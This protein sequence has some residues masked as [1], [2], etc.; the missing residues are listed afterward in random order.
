ML[1]CVDP[2]GSRCAFGV[3]RLTSGVWVGAGEELPLLF[4]SELRLLLAIF[5]LL[6]CL[7]CGGQRTAYREYECTRAL[8]VL[9]VLEDKIAKY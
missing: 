7:R 4:S 2:A 3:R 9:A 1:G 5:L 8:G 6:R